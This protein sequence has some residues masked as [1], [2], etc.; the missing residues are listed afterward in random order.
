MSIPGSR[1]S[2]ALLAAIAGLGGLACLFPQDEGPARVV[3]YIAPGPHPLTSPD[4]VWSGVAFTATV[5]TFGTPCTS[6]D[7]ARVTFHANTADVTPYD[8]VQGGPCVSTAVPLPRPI[9]LTFPTAGTAAIY[10]HGR[11][12]TGEAVTVSKAL[13]VV[14]P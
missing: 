4:T 6:P 14:E 5:T 3:G 2:R 7:G 12:G 11:A 10:L 9:V 13:T 1:L 8:R